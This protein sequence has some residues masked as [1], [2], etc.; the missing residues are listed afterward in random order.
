MKRHVLIVGLVM[1]AGA[2]MATALPVR[3]AV[4]PHSTRAVEQSA[5][6]LALNAS[7]VL[8][9]RLDACPAPPGADVCAGRTISGLFPGLGSVTGTYEFLVKTGLPCGVGLG[10][11]LSYPI[12]IAVASKGDINIAVAEGPC[13]GEGSIR[14]QTQSFTVTGGTGIYAGVSGSGTL[15]RVLGMDTGNGRRGQERWTGTITVPG[16]EFDTTRPTLSGATRMTVKAKKSAKTTRV[17]FRVTALD[18]KDGSIPVACT[19]RSGSRFSIG[20]TGVSCSANDSSGNA[21]T[22]S[23][24]VIVRKAM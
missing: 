23:F 5:G 19:P 17:V 16:L 7:L 8:T 6:T 18:D 1:T 24:V 3:G 22:A 20:R 9:S 11:A 10:K 12:R 2:L 13:T 4:Q 15:A 14:T 21:K